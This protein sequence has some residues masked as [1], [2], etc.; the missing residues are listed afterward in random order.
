[1]IKALL[2]LAA[3]TLALWLLLT[4]PAHLLWPDDAIFA[5]STAAAAICWGP[6]A[7]TLAWTHWAYAGRPEQQVL[8]VFGGTAVRMAFVIVAGLI[9]FYSLESFQ[10]QRFW[11]FLVVYYLFTLALE[12]ILI[13]RSTA[14]QQAEP[15]G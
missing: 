3:G 11:I 15:K 8:A 6:T 12:M 7:L 4:F 2:A 14:V 13:V 1:M 9:L 10:Y 5:W